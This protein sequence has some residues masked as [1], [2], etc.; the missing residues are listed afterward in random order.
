VVSAVDP[1]IHCT[2]LTVDYETY[3]AAGRTAE[4]GNVF[5]RVRARVARNVCHRRRPAA[6][7]MIDVGAGE[8]RYL[9]IWHNLFPAAQ[10]MAVEASPTASARSGT[11]HPYADHL[12]ARAESL[13]LAW[14]VPSIE[15]LEH[16]ANP[17]AMVA[18]IRRM[19]VPGGWAPIS[20]PCGNRGSLEWSLNAARGAVAPAPGGGVRF[21]RTEDPTHLRRYRTHELVSLLEANGLRVRSVAFHAHGAMTLGH[22]LEYQMHLA[23]DVRRRSKRAAHLIPAALDQFALPDWWLLRRVPWA[24][25]QIPLARRGG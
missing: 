7:V 17:A 2:S 8:G 15:V 22:R 3:H 24:S 21:G 16:F 19:L 18:D 10:I 5:E 25:I 1:R 20:T 14:G 13:P 6:S 4:F 9:R 23:A 11:L 12:V